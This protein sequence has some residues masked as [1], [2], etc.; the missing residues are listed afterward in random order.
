VATFDAKFSGLTQQ[1][2][3]AVTHPVGG[4]GF[5][6]GATPSGAAA[7][8]QDFTLVGT[9]EELWESHLHEREYLGGC[10]FDVSL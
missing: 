2:E 6:P 4:R 8:Q 9:W 1:T 3:A 7:T 5:G 10:G